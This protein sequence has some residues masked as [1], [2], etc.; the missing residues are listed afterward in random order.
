MNDNKLIKLI[1]AQLNAGFKSIGV[2]ALSTEAG[3]IITTELGDN[4]TAE[5]MIID[6]KQAF[7][8]TRQGVTAR[9]TCYLHKLFDQR[10]GMPKRKDVWT[11]ARMIAEDGPVITTE[12][13]DYIAND[14]GSDG[15]MNHE[16]TQLMGSHFQISARAIQDPSNIDSLTAS[17]IANYASAILQNSATIAAFEAQDVG[18]LRITDV[19]NPY[20]ANDSDRFEAMP[21]FDFVLTHKQTIVTSTPVITSTQAQILSV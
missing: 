2:T 5:G 17:D 3:I 4:I 12:S 21:S 9:P 15:T 1:L 8:P 14:G 7:Q 10:I 16:E 18:I 19:R 6:L 11:G 13:G 20:F